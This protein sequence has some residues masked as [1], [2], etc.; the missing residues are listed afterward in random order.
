MWDEHPTTPEK[1]I[2]SALG[3][4]LFSGEDVENQSSAM[5]VKSTGCFSQVSDEQRK[6][7]ILDEPTK[8][9]RY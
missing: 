3:A 5:A 7:L 2:R 1:E 9:F 6:F 8:P 4:F